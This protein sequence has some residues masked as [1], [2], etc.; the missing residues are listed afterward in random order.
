[1]LLEIASGLLSL[2]ILLLAPSRGL[3]TILPLALNIS[4]LFLD[5]ANGLLVTCVLSGVVTF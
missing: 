3:V 2:A 5:L 1:M 4:K